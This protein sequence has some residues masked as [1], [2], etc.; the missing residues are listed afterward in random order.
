MIFL[1]FCPNPVVHSAGCMC[2]LFKNRKGHF[3]LTKICL[4]VSYVSQDKQWVYS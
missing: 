4:I 3:L 2:Q 1:T